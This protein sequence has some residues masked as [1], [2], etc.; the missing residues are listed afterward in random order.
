[1]IPCPLTTF[2]LTYALAKQVLAA[3][4]LITAAMAAGMVVTIGGIALAAALARTRLSG[5][6]A[7]TEDW[8]HRVGLGLEVGSAAL[9]LLIGVATL[10]QSTRT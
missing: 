8:R 6:L 9:V 10:I 5:L 2:V 7:R 4:L 3:G 1:M